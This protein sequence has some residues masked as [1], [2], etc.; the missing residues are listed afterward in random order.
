MKRYILITIALGIVSLFQLARFTSEFRGVFPI[1]DA[2][3]CMEYAR[4]VTKGEVFT[5]NEG[6]YS[7][8]ITCPLYA[9]TLA[10]MKPAFKDWHHASITLGWICWLSALVLGTVIIFPYCNYWTCIFF[11]TFFGLSGRLAHFALFGMEPMMFIALALLSIFFYTKNKWRLTGFTACLATLCRP[12]GL[13]LFFLMGV[14]RF[15]KTKDWKSVLPLLIGF[16]PILIWNVYCLNVSGTLLSATVTRKSAKTLDLA[17]AFGF[18]WQSLFLNYPND[19]DSELIAKSVP[20]TMLMNIK[21]V[22][23]ITLA[24][25]PALWI[26]FKHIPKYLPMLLFVP[27]HICIA[28]VKSPTAA[29]WD[30]YMALD[31]AIIYVALAIA[32]SR[33]VYRKYIG[34]VIF[35]LL[36]LLQLNDY[37]YHVKAYNIKAQYFYH[38]DYKIGMWLKQ[39]TPPDTRAVAFQAGG[40]KFF[41]ERYLVDMGGVTDHTI[42][43]EKKIETI[44][45]RDVDYIASFGDGWLD[46][47]GFSLSDRR[48]FE[49]IPLQCRG[50]YKV[51]NTFKNLKTGE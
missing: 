42:D 51:K 45:K 5:Y 23:P 40:I 48:Y 14:F 4:N 10:A 50:L 7:T 19:W 37:S 9:L 44:L 43:R 1:D 31:Y 24:L 34:Y 15:I 28:A 35:V 20:N 12:E 39:N 36:V 3:I 17:S 21:Q 22:V 6:I 49:R 46:R 32:L 27:L 33:V 16:S 18:I 30:R 26:S 25:I 38:L 41:S 2:Y 13:F 29:E 11:I 47:E 8:G